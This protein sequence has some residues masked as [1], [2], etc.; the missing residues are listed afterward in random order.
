MSSNPL[1][2][3]RFLHLPFSEHGR[4][5]VGLE[6]VSLQAAYFLARPSRHACAGPRP[7]ACGMVSRSHAPRPAGSS[8]ESCARCE[9]PRSLSRNGLRSSPRRSA[10]QFRDPLRHEF[11]IRP[12]RSWIVRTRLHKHH[13]GQISLVGRSVEEHEPAAVGMTRE[14]EGRLHAPPFLAGYAVPT[15]VDAWFVP[16]NRDRSSQ[17]CAVIRAHAGEAGGCRPYESPI[18]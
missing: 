10:A 16:V 13:S 18:H 2:N 9:P 17:T 8:L 15:S 6:G 5:F 11:P 14:H 4:H 3:R 1:A 7:T 12:H